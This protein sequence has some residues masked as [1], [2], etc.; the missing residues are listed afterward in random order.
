MRA[1]ESL[2]DALLPPRESAKLLRHVEEDALLPFLTPT[3]SPLT[4]PVVVSLSS[5]KEPLVRAAIA[6]AKFHASRKGVELLARLL[7]EYAVELETEYT[8][9]FT[10]VVLIPLP[11]SKRRKRERG[12]N[13]VER[14]VV[15]SSVGVDAPYLRIDTKILMRTRHTKP[16]TDLPK[17]ER[18]RNVVGAFEAHGAPAPHTLYIV[19]DD[20][21]TTGATLIS[22]CKALEAAGYTHVEGLALAH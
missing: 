2:L 20:V 4:S 18:L 12:Y 1:L 3:L 19:V 15:R 8:P 10:H 7:Q 21:L 16:Q 6:E 13:Q 9:R 14:I 11:L 17:K 22:A 5:Y